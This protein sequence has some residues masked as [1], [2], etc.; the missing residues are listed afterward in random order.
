MVVVVINLHG[1]RR[2]ERFRGVGRILPAL[3]S[4]ILTGTL[5]A[6]LMDY[7]KIFSSDGFEFVI[8]RRCAM[9]SGTIRNMLSSP[10]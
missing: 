2:R 10:G 3:I 5:V 8:E 1:D 9:K 7:V 6:N 4:L